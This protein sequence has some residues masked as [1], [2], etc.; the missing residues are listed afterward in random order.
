MARLPQPGGD[1][2]NWGSIL[3]DYLSQAHKSDGTLK[4]NAVT[5]NVLAPSSVTSSALA[6]DSVN[7]T[8]IVD[9]SITSVKIDTDAIGRDQLKSD[10]RTELDSKLTKTIADNNY[11]R[12]YSVLRYVPAGINPTTTDVSVYV[13]QVINEAAANTG[14]SE[15]IVRWPAQTIMA[16]IIIPSNVRIRGSSQGLSVIKAVPGST[17]KG[18]V[19]MSQAGG[20]ITRFC[21]EDVAI[22]GS[23]ANPN[24]WGLYAKTP[25]R[26][27]SPFD[28]GIW[29]STLKN[30]RVTNTLG[31]GI[32]LFGGGVNSLGPMQF[33]NFDNV[34]IQITSGSAPNWIGLLLSGQVGQV[35]FNQVESSYRG[36]GYG[37]RSLL[38][39]R[40]ID[41]A[42]NNIS[43]RWGYALTFNACTFQGTN[44]GVQV[45]RAQGVAFTSCWIEDNHSGFLISN[46]AKGVTFTSC[47]FADTGS[48]GAGGGYVGQ[49]TDTS[50][51]TVVAPMVI[52]AID[53][54]WKQ[55]A[56]SICNLDVIGGVDSVNSVLS[57]FPKNLAATGNV[58][59]GSNRYVGIT[60]SA[61][62]NSITATLEHGQILCVRALSALN[63]V[64]TGGNIRFASGQPTTQKTF[65]I[66]SRLIFVYDKAANNMTLISH[67][68]SIQ[69][70]TAL[71]VTGTAG[72]GFIGLSSQTATPALPASGVRM[73]SRV[74]GSSKSELCVQFATGSPIV[75]AVQV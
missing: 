57:G 39:A 72:A 24:Q 74:N 41:D 18:V 40:E 6:S 69:D 35:I 73:F 5:A 58:L 3:N 54:L 31:G 64:G 51:A 46:N 33:L 21:I 34:S 70:V 19:M 52:G 48:D 2:G 4:D 47:V 16:E 63:I 75:I 36:S 17:N 26:P 45:D 67:S 53:T 22:V 49:V 42:M 10:L 59:I 25:P 43:D 8:S 44:V 9:G 50:S 29:Y 28:S 14:D 7:A 61:S 1:G 11:T 27:V 23:S 12:S 13:Q 38:I 15:P 37:S 65:D 20:P 30:V 56:S 32:W 71:N 62:I 55:N 66:G 68:S 60:G